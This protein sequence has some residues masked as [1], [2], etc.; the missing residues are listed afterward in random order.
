M[1]YAHIVKRSPGLDL[2][3][4]TAFLSSIQD[5]IGV[6]NTRRKHKATPAVA[7]DDWYPMNTAAKAQS[8]FWAHLLLP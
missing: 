8:D 7:Q 2:K 4:P 1:Q 6:F 3:M 5:H